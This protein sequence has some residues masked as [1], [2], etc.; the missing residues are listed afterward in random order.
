MKE[1]PILF[2]GAMVRALLNGSKTQTR[3]VVRPQPPA[4]AVDA[5]VIISNSASNGEW[6]WLDDPDLEWAGVVG[7]MFRCPYGV[8][9]DRLWVRE[10]FSI[11]D[12]DLSRLENLDPMAWYWAEGNPTAGNWTKPRPSIHMPRW[13][14]RLTL[15]IVNVGV[16]RLTRIR[17]SDCYD[18]GIRRPAPGAIGNEKVGFENAQRAYRELWDDLNA[19]RGFAWDT[20]PWVWVLTFRT[21]V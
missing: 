7:E 8:P 15:E 12:Y 1:R 2:S 11:R 5:G 9:G 4:Q 20:N 19:A 17:A 18:E 13:A 14:S 21:V 6:S 10:S 3:R 16:E